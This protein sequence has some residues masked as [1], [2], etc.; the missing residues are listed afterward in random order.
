MR[1]AVPKEIRD[2]ETRV[3]A[4]PESVK[5]FKG[6]GLDV[7][8]Q[9]GAGAGAKIA[10]AD[11][12]AAGAAIAPDA[13]ATYRDADIVLKVR[14]PEAGETALL[15]NGAVLAAL[16]SPATEQAAVQSLAG[17]GVVAFAMELLPRISRAQAMDVLSSQANLAGYKAVV[18]AA[19]TFGRAMPMMMTAAGTIAPAR[20][21]VMGVGVAGLQAIATAKR[22]GA[23]V[24]ATDVRPATKEQVESLGGT[25]IAVM[26]DE[27]KNAQTA[28][29]Y[30]K[31]MSEEYQ[32]KQAALIAETIK[33]QDIVITTALIPGRKAPILV[34]ED[35]I[36]SMKPGSVIVDLAAGAGGN[37][38]LSRPDQ[39]VEAHGVTIM[40]HTNLPGALAVDA[41]ALYARNLFN[42]VSLI[43]DKKTGALNID[44]N[45]EIVKGSAVT[46]DGAPVQR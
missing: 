3:A 38:P 39:V 7:V 27:F 24:S 30:A 21:L 11:Y 28:A 15:K 25:F 43:V 44:W 32:K 13:A 10:D 33:K 4:T 31:P 46:K 20:V 29:G 22:M 14:G 19:A 36:K 2:G 41:S 23:I 12:A 17:Q 5:K 45:D 6:L 9:A 16:L 34:S 40:G 1:L 8:V 42:F 37:T 26:D 18:D 35:M